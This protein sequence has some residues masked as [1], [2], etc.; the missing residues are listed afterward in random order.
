MLIKLLLSISLIFG[1]AFLGHQEKKIVIV[2]TPSLDG[3]DSIIYEEKTIYV[4]KRNT[5]ESIGALSMVL[6]GTGFFLW[7][8]KDKDAKKKQEIEDRKE[9]WERFRQLKKAK[10]E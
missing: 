10:Q 7:C 4:R 6:V 5:G 2:G 9:L 8:I 3:T 1:S